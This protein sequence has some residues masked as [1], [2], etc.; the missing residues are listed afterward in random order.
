MYYWLHDPVGLL[1]RLREQDLLT[2]DAVVT[3]SLMTSQQD[4]DVLLESVQTFKLI[5]EERGVE[6]TDWSEADWARLRV[7]LDELDKRKFI[8]KYGEDD[9]VEH[10][11]RAGYEITLRERPSYTVG[12]KPFCAFSFFVAK[13]VP[14]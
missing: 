7:S 14:R 1:K 9:V 8:G 10:L 6:F 5:Q 2:R 4:F 3:I 13:G 12:E 11:T